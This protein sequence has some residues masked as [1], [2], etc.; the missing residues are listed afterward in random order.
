P[1]TSAHAYKG[2]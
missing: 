2:A 1:P